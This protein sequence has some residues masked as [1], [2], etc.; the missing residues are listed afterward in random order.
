M[1]AEPCFNLAEAF[2]DVIKK[3]AIPKG[4]ECVLVADFEGTVHAVAYAT[5]GFSLVRTANQVLAHYSISTVCQLSTFADL[6][7]S[8]LCNYHSLCRQPKHNIA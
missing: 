5:L 3:N 2:G 7:D 8:K 1:P 6:P 4:T